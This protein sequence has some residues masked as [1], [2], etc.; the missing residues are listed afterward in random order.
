MI[1]GINGIIA[2]KGG[3]PLLLDTYSGAAAAYSLRK[4]RTAYTGNAITV[5][6]SS[7]N[8]SQ[9]IGFDSNGNLDTTSLLSFVGAGNGFVTTWFDQSG[10]NNN[11]SSSTLAEQPQIVSGGNLI[12]V[13][14]KPSIS[15]DGTNDYMNYS[16]IT[17]SSNHYN[18]T[19]IKRDTP[20]VR[21]F[22]LSG[23]DIA[24][25][26]LMTLWSDNNFYF[27]GKNLY[28]IASTSTDT[29][30][31]QILLTGVNNAGVLNIYKNSNIINTTLVNDN[32]ITATTN[33][34]GNYNGNLFSN[35]KIQEIVFYNN[36][37]SSNR[38]SISSN[39]NSHYTIY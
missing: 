29:T 35:A 16:T 21:M 11:A 37:Q 39:I 18:F 15:F 6:R 20:G 25:K 3:L 32:G 9:Q 17:C 36:D 7:D 24:S 23:R 19:V 22:G 5:R 30:T 13:N 14:G 2:G 28:Y 1:L 31:N 8:T 26:Y 33:S 4:L 38:T 27:Q 12:L 10:N 34:L